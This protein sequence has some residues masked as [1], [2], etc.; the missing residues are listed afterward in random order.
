MTGAAFVGEL[1]DGIDTVVG[2]RGL[3]LSGGQRQRIALARTLVRGCPIVL[4]D[5]PL[6]QLDARSRETVSDAIE[7]CTRSSVVI[8]AAHA[9]DNF[10]WATRSIDLHEMAPVP[11]TGVLEAATP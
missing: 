8:I 1:P 2:E 9:L 5:E 10:P 11:D 3:T 7:R 6:A 4:L